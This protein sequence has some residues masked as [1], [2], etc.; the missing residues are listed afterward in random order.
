[1]V[2]HESRRLRNTFC[3]PSGVTVRNSITTYRIIICRIISE[4]DS[5]IK[6]TKM[7][8]RLLSPLQL[9]GAEP[10]NA[11]SSINSFLMHISQ[12]QMQKTKMHTSTGSWYKL[13]QKKKLKTCPLHKNNNNTNFIQNRNF[14]RYSPIP[15]TFPMVQ[16]RPQGAFP[17]LWRWEVADGI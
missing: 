7:L 3:K 15:I 1:M 14:S 13:R 11:S 16:P 12:N 5:P 2:V 4:G 8:S 6:I 17:W 9:P 10:S